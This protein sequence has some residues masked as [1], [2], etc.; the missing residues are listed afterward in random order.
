VWAVLGGISRATTTLRVGTGVTCPTIRIHPALVAQAAATVQAMFD[1]R[2]YLGLGSGENLNE[3]ILGDRW[4][5]P[6]QRLDMLEEA[7]AVIRLLWQ[8]GFQSF[9]GE[10]FEVDRAR[11]Y[12]LPDEPPPIYVAAA[13][14]EAAELAARCGDGL[15][16][17]APQNALV[18]GFR[19]SGGEGKPR[20]GQL[21][22][23]WAGTEREG[24]DTILEHWP[25]AGLQGSLNQEL[26]TPGEFEAAVATVRPEDVKALPAGPDPE[27]HLEGIRA[28]VEAGFDHVF[29]HQVGPDQ[30]GFFRFYEREILPQFQSAPAPATHVSSQSTSSQLH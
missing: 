28:F 8:G 25:T 4:P 19:K 16:A 9:E 27:R 26:A 1:G 23:C 13:G 17:V 14:P 20:Y 3:H 30:E 18:D 22:V 5:R 7:I 15:I 11:V 6:A 21:T 29:V 2:F 12:S 10:F 24:V